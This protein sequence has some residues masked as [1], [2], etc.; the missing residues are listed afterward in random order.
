MN[1]LWRDQLHAERTRWFV[2]RD[3]ER[4]RFQ[5]ALQ[6]GKGPI[7]Y[8][9]GPPGIGKTTLLRLWQSIAEEHGLAALFI[10]GRFLDPRTDA[11]LEVVGQALGISPGYRVLQ[12]LSQR[13][14]PLALFLDTFEA[15]Q[16]LENWLLETFLPHL[17]LCTWVAIGSRRPPSLAWR[18]D[19]GWRALVEVFPLRNLT[20][21]EGEEYLRQRG[22]PEPYHRP[23]LHLTWGHPLALALAAD[24]VAQQPNRPPPAELPPHLLQTLLHLF[25]AELPTPA[26]RETLEASALVRWLTEPLLAEI[27]GKEESAQ[28]FEW[29]QRLS[30][31][32]AGPRGLRPHDLVREI[33]LADLRWR[34]PE[35]YQTLHRRAHAYYARRL[36][37]LPE[38]AQIE[39]LIDF[40]YLHREHP[41]LRPFF[42]ELR[43]RWSDE[44]SLFLDRPEPMEYGE[45]L[46]MIARH[47]GETSA[48]IADHWFQ[49]QPEGIMV[50]RS[51]HLRIAG[52]LAVLRLEAISPEERKRDPAIAAALAYLER[53]APLRPGERAL[54]FRFWMDR[55]VYQALS[56]AQ[57]LI[58]V[59]MVRMCL[60]TPSLAFSF[61]PCADPAFWAPVFGYAEI[62][63]LPEADFEIDGRHYGVYGQDWRATPIPLW[64]ARLGEKEAALVPDAEIPKP[65]EPIVVLNLPE[66]RKAVRQALRDLHR[67]DHLKA[68]PLAYSRLVLTQTGPFA[69]AEQRGTALKALLL[70]AARRLQTDPKTAKH[71][72][73]LHATYIEPLGTQEQAAERLDLP[74]STY[75]R[76]LKT[77]LDQITAWLWE[78]ELK[79]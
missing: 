9:F 77:A 11:F 31:I 10:D 36:R 37:E 32:E 51:Q 43:L 4:K 2:G 7:F 17:P 79:Y 22:I 34:N 30:F 42:A 46:A 33:L 39:L 54:Y 12:T 73:V 78:Q 57:S 23:L 41:L 49:Q 1:R 61:F 56:P 63:R 16:P 44:E 55:E 72:Q 70:E 19:P 68:N 52:L 45:L 35:R 26:Y 28:L 62:P 21:R 66:F 13:S 5:E 24:L 27:L 47:E 53:H 76:Y 8:V 75:R 25:L 18:A 74:I 67:P 40:I 60:T 59:Q 48:A 15:L 3:R 6:S 50:V 65:P 14:E 20:P 38:P 64:L 58:G 29:L 71:Y 69:S